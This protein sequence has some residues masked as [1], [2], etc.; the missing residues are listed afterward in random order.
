MVLSA[1]KS[2]RNKEDTIVHYCSLCGTAFFKIEDVVVCEISHK[3]A[4]RKNKGIKQGTL[5]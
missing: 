2:R 4:H 1:I 3:S 5:F